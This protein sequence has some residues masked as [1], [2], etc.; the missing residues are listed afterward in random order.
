MFLHSIHRPRRILAVL[1]IPLWGGRNDVAE[2]AYE[3]SQYLQENDEH[4]QAEST[5]AIGGV[6]ELPRPPRKVGGRGGY[7][8]A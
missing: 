6:M 3:T 8:R 5:A 7:A 4:Y 2:S 1:N